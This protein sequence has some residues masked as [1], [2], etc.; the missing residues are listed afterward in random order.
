M[1]AGTSG[2]TYALSQLVR[3]LLWQGAH[4]VGQLGI[5]APKTKSDARAR[6]VDTQTLEAIDNLAATLVSALSL[7]DVARAL[8]TREVAA[9]VGIHE[10]P[11]MP[12]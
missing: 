9:E 4:V 2:G 6:L 10:Y 7:T 8:R 3:T 11:H 5:A 12:E 1:S